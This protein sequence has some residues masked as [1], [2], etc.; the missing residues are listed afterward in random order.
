M[1]SF[2][3]CTIAGA[4]TPISISS[5]YG[6]GSTIFLI[7]QD[8]GYFA[9][10]GLNVTIVPCEG[11]FQCMDDMLA[12]RSD[13]S[14]GGDLAIMFRALERKDFVVLATLATSTS[15]LKLLARSSAQVSSP[16]D[17]IGKRVGIIS[18][19]A[20][21]YFLH[22]YLLKAGIDP[23]KLKEIVLQPSTMSA[24]FARG[25]VDVL[26]TYE[27][28]ASKQ[29]KE[30]GKQ[31]S[32]V[33]IPP[34]FNLGVHLVSLR[35]TVNERPDETSR[36]LLALVRAEQFIRQEPA[37]ARQ[38]WMKRTG[39]SEAEAEA[40]WG[41]IKFKM[42]LE[43]SLITVLDGAARWAQLEGLAHTSQLPNFHEL[44]DT[45]PLTKAKPEGVIK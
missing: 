29:R 42:T 34:I 4:A 2:F 43:P 32:E 24:A 8:R 22:M 33:A 45:A 3:G 28:L 30:F 16:K 7:A 36:L 26:S 10:E 1:L 9:Q 12:G 6:A 15:I 20:P 5:G 11:A 14:N 44:I 35:R 13:F 18:K 19:S 40:A 23:H 25:E 39:V 21:H 37:K 31:I 27:P 38:I 17:L 41:G